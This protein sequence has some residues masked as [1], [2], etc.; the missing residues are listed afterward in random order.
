MQKVNSVA[1]SQDKSAYA[2][3]F[4][5]IVV[6]HLDTNVIFRGEKENILRTSSA[7]WNNMFLI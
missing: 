5:K 1:A 7:K 2:D 3:I 4:G 6:E